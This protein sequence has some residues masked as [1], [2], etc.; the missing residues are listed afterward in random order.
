VSMRVR[1]ESGQAIPITVVVM[2]V[3]IAAVAFSLDVGS[4]YRERRQAQTAADAAALSGAQSLPSNTL[5]AS[6]SATT[7]ANSNGGGVDGVGGITFQDGFQPHDTVTVKI[8]RTAPGFLARIFKIDSVQ[9]HAT[10]VAR[11]AVP[12]NVKD[13]T[14]IVV[15]EHH[16]DLLGNAGCPCFNL[17]TTIPLGKDGAPGSFGMIDL[18]QYQAAISGSCPSGTGPG[19]DGT[20][21]L[22]QWITTG[23][24]KYLA[25]GCYTSDTGAKF[26]SNIIAALQSRLG[27]NLLFPVYST[28]YGPGSNAQYNIVG[29]A[30]FHLQS[31]DPSGS[32][33]TITGWFT[34]VIWDGIQSS[35]APTGPDFGVHTIALIN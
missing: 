9:V 33:G 19:N 34:Q 10:A 24:D 1:D 12:L 23:F 5:A 28:L 26:N 21:V 8:T 2:F 32:N 31:F 25:L 29:W 15:N 35:T 6:T 17:T 30:A 27:T 7:F 16:P 13:V 3:L 4:W 18:D 20:S 11:S 22:G 14:P